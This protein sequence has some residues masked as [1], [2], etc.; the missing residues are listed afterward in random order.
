MPLTGKEVLFEKW[1]QGYDCS[2]I[3]SLGHAGS[4]WNAILQ[5]FRKLLR[6]ERRSHHS[7]IAPD[8]FA[9]FVGELQRFY[10]WGE[11]FS[12]SQGRLDE[13]LDKST[14]LQHDTIFILEQLGRALSVDLCTLLNANSA[15]DP[16]LIVA[17]K[18]VDDMHKVVAT[19]LRTTDDE[20]DPDL[21]SG[22]MFASRP[23]FEITPPDAHDILGDITDYIDSLMDLCDALE[24]TAQDADWLHDRDAAVN[25]ESFDVLPEADQYCRR[26]RDQYPFLPRFLVERLGNLNSKRYSRLRYWGNHTIAQGPDLD[27][28]DSKPSVSGDPTTETR[29]STVFDKD[30]WHGDAMSLSTAETTD[31]GN[32]KGKPRVPPLPAEAKDGAPFR[33]PICH[34]I[35]SGITSRAEWKKHVFGDLRPYCCVAEDCNLDSRGETVY[36]TYSST[37]I[38]IQHLTKHFKTAFSGKCPFCGPS[39]P[40]LAQQKLVQHIRRHLQD[41]SLSVLPQSSQGIHDSDDHDEDEIKDVTQD[42]IQG[43]SL[44]DSEDE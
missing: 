26:I 13:I 28:E 18:E 31:F 17:V 30:S 1:R 36:L 11:G 34:I 21:G 33:C 35:V 29:S 9:K 27:R 41:I 40:L 2:T 6:A 10:F 14:E 22:F 20:L 12:A 42:L 25:P 32:T 43:D 4:F 38:W 19:L 15:L 7:T 44:H 3:P 24:N 23:E 37:G 39:S 16:E 8:L 5:L